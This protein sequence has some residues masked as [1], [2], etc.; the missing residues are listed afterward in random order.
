MGQGT[1]NG[2]VGGRPNGSAVGRKIEQHDGDLSVGSRRSA[3]P[4]QRRYPV[5]KALD[6]LL[7]GMHIGLTIT[8]LGP[9]PEDRGR[10]RA[11]ELG[12]GNHDRRFHRRQP[13]GAAGPLLNGLKLQGVGCEVGHVKLAKYRFRRLR[14]VVG[15]AADQGKARQGE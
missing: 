15:R 13:L 10:C 12:N 7:N 1:P 5:G 6:P 14:I 11:I 3:Q 8:T 4:G 2:K 9:S